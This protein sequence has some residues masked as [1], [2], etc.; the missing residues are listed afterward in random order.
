MGFCILLALMPVKGNA[1]LAPPG[2]ARRLRP[3]ARPTG[4]V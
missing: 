4:G 1:A 3:A 2:R